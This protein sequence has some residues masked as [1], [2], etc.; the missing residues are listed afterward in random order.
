MLA[1]FSAPSKLDT[2]PFKTIWQFKRSD[3]TEYYI[4][5]ALD[6]TRPCWMRLGH[7]MEAAFEHH[8]INDSSFIDDLIRLIGM[9]VVKIEEL[10]S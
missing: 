4:Q 10:E 5:M 8:I 2:A 9:R 6:E 7:V 3:S 1:K